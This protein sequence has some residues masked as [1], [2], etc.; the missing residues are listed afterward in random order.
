MIRDS[1]GNGWIAKPR[2]G[3]RVPLRSLGGASTFPP[4]LGAHGV[5]GWR[6]EPPTEETNVAYRQLIGREGRGTRI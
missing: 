2:K 5:E 3:T 1:Q 6:I 4:M